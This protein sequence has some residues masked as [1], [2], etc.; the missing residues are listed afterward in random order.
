MWNRSRI[1]PPGLRARAR[2]RRTARKPALRPPVDFRSPRQ[3]RKS[4]QQPPCLRFLS[5][6]FVTPQV[7]LREL[8]LLQTNRRV[9]PLTFSGTVSDRSLD[10]PR[11]FSCLSTISQSSD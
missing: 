3:I 5:I 11:H 9:T 8:R 2:V 1:Q 6:A 10:A 7:G 4:E